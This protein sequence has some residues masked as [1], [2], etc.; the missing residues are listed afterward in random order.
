M[1]QKRR[2]FT[3]A[4]KV[5][6]LKRH[7]LEKEP[8]SQV[9]DEAQIAPTQFYAWQAKLFEHAEEVLRDAR[10]KKP[11][12]PDQ[13]R[14]QLLEARLREREEALAELMTE[15]VALKKSSIGLA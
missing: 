8:I 9:C 13:Q 15:H 11:T 4:E 1:P 10:G 12:H 5:K 3:E 2:R 6:I 14:I 7:L